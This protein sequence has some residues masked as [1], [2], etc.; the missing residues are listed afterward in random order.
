MN[1]MK[2]FAAIGLAAV[3]TLGCL[4]GC[5]SEQK[6]DGMQTIATVGDEKIS[7]GTLM[8]MLRFQQA[9]TYDYYQSMSEMYASQGYSIDVSNMFDRDVSNDESESSDSKDKDKD[10]EKTG[11]TVKT[12]GESLVE[13]VATALTS[14]AVLEQK[15]SDYGVTLTDSDKES[16]KKA[17]KSF[18]KDSD[19][20]SLA[21]NGITQDDVEKLLTYYTYYVK[22]YDVY[23][24]KADVTVT[25]DET[26][27]MTVS[28]VKF[29]VSDD[30]KSDVKKSAED[31]L[32][33]CQD[34]AD[35][36]KD[37]ENKAKDVDGASFNS[38][39]MAVNNTE[40]NAY[41]F[42]SDQMKKII[43]TE[44][45]AVYNK[46][47]TDS[48]GNYYVVRMDNNNDKD[49]AAS[50]S[51]TLKL[52]KISDA[53]QKDLKSWKKDVKVTYKSDLLKKI[54]VTDNVVYTGTKESDS[55]S[56]TNTSTSTSDSSTD[57][58]ADSII[59][60]ETTTETGK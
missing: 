18:V 44:N 45:G 13:N 12:S 21:N 57:S 38:G 36:L 20:K 56:T 22:V 30:K 54:K 31:F 25:D 27:S 28:Y 35:Y 15:A 1:K 17:A 48:D 50:Y 51:E 16:I 43:E 49:A 26:K 8:S 60:T 5:S 53:F 55:D 41:V 14:Y 6:L 42:T 40:E 19:E 7:M 29:A 9:T 37:M 10:A 32:K 33:K 24:E 52:S 34:D 59:S 11:L 47:V 39:S 3:M 4:T 58:S 2:K 23:S 46:V